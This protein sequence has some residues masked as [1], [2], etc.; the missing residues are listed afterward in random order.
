[1][2]FCKTRQISFR[3]EENR[4]HESLKEQGAGQS[5]PKNILT[6]TSATRVIIVTA[7]T[8]DVLVIIVQLLANPSPMLVPSPRKQTG[9]AAINVTSGCSHTF[10]CPPYPYLSSS[11]CAASTSTLRVNP[12]LELR[13]SNVPGVLNV[14]LVE[15]NP[16]MEFE[17]CDYRLHLPCSSRPPPRSSPSRLFQEVE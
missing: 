8:L 4:A 5:T 12:N 14:K 2:I 3:T 1:M 17:H 16:V 15:C 11:S 13:A 10:P 6:G 9:C 7:P